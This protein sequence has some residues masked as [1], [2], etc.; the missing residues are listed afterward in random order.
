LTSAG[1]ELE[2]DAMSVKLELKSKLNQIRNA[3][4]IFLKFKFLY[5]NQLYLYFV[6]GRHLPLVGKN[7][8][9]MTVPR[10]VFEIT[11]MNFVQRYDDW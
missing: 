11:L 4:E 7:Y 5:G 9:K 3:R 8:T 6:R 2:R 10:V 1:E